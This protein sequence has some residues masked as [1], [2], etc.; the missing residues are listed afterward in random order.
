VSKKVHFISSARLIGGLTLLSRI[1]GLLRDAIC[2]RFFGTEVWH[3]F[4]VPF[5]IPNLLRRLFGEG[6][7]SAALIPVYSE[8]RHQDPEGARRLARSVVT[9]LIV[10][11][12]GL[13][14]VGLG[15]IYLCWLLSRREFESWLVLSLAAL[16]LPYMILICTVAAVGGLLNV[17]RHFAAPAA[18]PI[19]LNVCI[20]AMVLW[21]REYFGSGPWKQIFSVATAVLIAG[22]LQLLLQYP[23]LRRHGI[24]LNLLWDFSDPALKRIMRLMGPMVVGLSVVQ[25]NVLLDSLIAYFLSGKAGAETFMMGGWTVS[26]PVRVG[27]V[28]HLYCAQRLYQFPLGVFGVALATAIFPYLSQYAAEKDRENFS[29]TLGQGLRMVVFLAVPATVGIVLVRIPYVAVVYEGRAF[30]RAD[31]MAVART[32]LFYTL[33]ITAYFMQQLVVRGYYSFQ[34]S[35]TPVK[36]AVRM[37]G[38]NFVLNLVLIWPLGTG[39]LGLSTAICAAVQAVW[40]LRL[41]IRRYELE[42]TDGLRASVTKTALASAVLAI[43]GLVAWTYLRG[44]SQLVQIVIVVPVCV[45]LF[46]GT[47][48]LLRHPELS[49]LLHRT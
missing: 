49:L 21:F 13:T 2:L 4:T 46:A 47:A 43:G 6:A 28:A 36:V 38:L 20:I 41:L 17:H 48:R 45:V 40:L 29:R 34:D 39:G 14:L 27:S 18:A 12:S 31:T 32:L 7:L 24:D 44:S 9:L 22:V 10:V 1:L 25:I 42:I 8:K 37:V 26:Y 11:L 3:Y 16:M 15:I 5:Q 19:L 23:A 35:L 33:G 30:T